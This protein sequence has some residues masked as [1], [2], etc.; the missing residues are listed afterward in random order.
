MAKEP[1]WALGTR[2]IFTTEKAWGPT[3]KQRPPFPTEGRADVTTDKEGRFVVPIIAEGRLS[4]IEVI[5]DDKLPVRPEL[6]RFV[7]LSAGTTTVLE[8][9][10]RR[11]VDI[12][13]SILAQDTGQPLPG[14]EI[15][16]YYGEFR[17]GTDVVSDAKGQFSARVLPGEVSFQPLTLAKTKYLQ[18]G[19]P[20]SHHVPEDADGFELPAIEVV[21]SV[22]VDGRLVD[23]DDVPVA[24]SEVIAYFDNYLCSA[25][26][27]DKDGRFTLPKMPV[28]IDLGE[29]T[30]RV[31]LSIGETRFMHDGG[32]EI[33]GVNPLVLRVKR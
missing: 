10:M 15:H 17:Q 20:K 16:V 12:R 33:I 29:V 25:A 27:T 7:D 18:L 1:E 19:S 2:L 4:M 8:L 11:L 32:V 6:P 5:L 31:A 21:P 28:S 30:Y 24:D 13:G 22:P 3:E 23:Q 9:P 26:T 14:I